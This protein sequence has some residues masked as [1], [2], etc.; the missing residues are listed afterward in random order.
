M[1]NKRTMH[2]ATGWQYGTASIAKW[3]EQ[4]LEAGEIDSRDIVWAGPD[5][6]YAVGEGTIEEEESI[7][8][9]VDE[10]SVSEWLEEAAKDTLRE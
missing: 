3:L 7:V 4:L 6:G 2:T 1:T 5:G 10:G 9:Y 8:D